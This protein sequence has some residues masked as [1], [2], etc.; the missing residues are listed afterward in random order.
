M[1]NDKRKET[2]EHTEFKAVTEGA[3]IVRFKMR[4]IDCDRSEPTLARV[5]MNGV[6]DT[7]PSLNTAYI[8]GEPQGPIRFQIKNPEVARL[9][10]EGQDYYV[11]FTP[12]FQE[13]GSNEGVPP[14]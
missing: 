3:K 13:E 8:A 10:V 1:I 6:F 11:D 2:K 4:V 14:Q 12:T 7:E 9:F 5:R